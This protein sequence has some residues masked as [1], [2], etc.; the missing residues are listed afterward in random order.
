MDV[1]GIVLGYFEDMTIHLNNV[2]KAG[3]V[4]YHE[5]FHSLFRMAFKN[6]QRDLYLNAV[7][8]I[9]GGVKVMQVVNTFNIKVL[10]HTLGILKINAGLR[11]YQI[12]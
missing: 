10:R 3:G 8:T 5:A 7:K 6:S 4:A 11:G 9:S 2:V 12:R 1:K